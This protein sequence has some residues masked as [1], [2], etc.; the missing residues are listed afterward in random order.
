MN[1]IQL[2]IVAT[3][4]IWGTCALRLGDHNHKAYD[5]A[6]DYLQGLQSQQFKFEAQIDAL[7]ANVEKT[8]S[9][10]SAQSDIAQKISILENGIL[11]Q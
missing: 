4:L 6:A 8:L 9:D 2:A 3:L 11:N 7:E 10:A 1:K 5:N